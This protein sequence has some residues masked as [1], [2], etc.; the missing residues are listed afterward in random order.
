MSL[1]RNNIL[2]GPRLTVLLITLAVVIAVASIVLPRINNIAEKTRKSPQEM[3][4]ENYSQAPQI[5]AEEKKSIEGSY[6]STSMK[7]TDK[8]RK[9]IEFNYVRDVSE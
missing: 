6:A 1:V 7:L 8:E 9:Q 5:T 4:E 3:I 2:I